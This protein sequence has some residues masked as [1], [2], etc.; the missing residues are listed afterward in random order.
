MCCYVYLKI[1]LKSWNVFPLSI[2]LNLVFE[3]GCLLVLFAVLILRRLHWHTYVGA[4]QYIVIWL[5]ELCLSCTSQTCTFN[6]LKYHK[7]GI[8][9]Q[10][11][12]DFML[13]QISLFED[14]LSQIMGQNADKCHKTCIRLMSFLCTVESQVRS[15]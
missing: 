1:N 4:S 6:V 15:W 12:I 11:D 13:L 9:L 8:N 10:K 2:A 14:W 5:L 7:K 3:S